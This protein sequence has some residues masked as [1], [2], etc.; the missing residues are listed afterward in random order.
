MIFL[1]HAG[2]GPYDEILYLGVA[3]IFTAFMGVSWWK[4]RNFEAYIEEET[5]EEKPQE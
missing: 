4:S 5:D 3:I 1:A 2:L